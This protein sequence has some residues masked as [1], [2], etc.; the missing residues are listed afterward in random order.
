MQRAVRLLEPQAVFRTFA[1]ICPRYWP[2]HRPRR[3]VYLV[4]GQ[5]PV[6]KH[7]RYWMLAL[8]AATEPMLDEGLVKRA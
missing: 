3:M 4:G 8:A 5:S 6:C 2:K 1:A 7:S